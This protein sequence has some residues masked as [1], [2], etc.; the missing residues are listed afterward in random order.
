M[1]IEMIGDVRGW[2]HERLTACLTA[3]SVGLAD[4]TTFY[5]VELLASAGISRRE[6]LCGRPLVL[7]L[8]DATQ[9]EGGE[10]LR[11]FRTLGDEA[12]YVGGFFAD[13]LE[14]R[15]VTETYVSRL[16]TQAYETASQLAARNAHEAT[17]IGVYRELAALFAPITRVLDDVR[18]STALR[19]PQDIVRLY[20]KWRRTGSPRIAARLSAEGVYPGR[21]PSGTVH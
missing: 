9:A 14:R 20:D 7:I 10:R 16:G 21:G 8:A 15:G 1:T 17:R 3:R 6:S 4:E 12:L 2:F 11:L 13:H 18:E 5:L 19:T